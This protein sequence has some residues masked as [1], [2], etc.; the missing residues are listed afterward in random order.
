MLA[1]IAAVF[2][3]FA[4]ALTLPGCANSKAAVDPFWQGFRGLN[5]DVARGGDW[6]PTD[7]DWQEPVG[8]R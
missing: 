7:R 5:S 8:G 2:M 4:L 1:R 3:V 6:G